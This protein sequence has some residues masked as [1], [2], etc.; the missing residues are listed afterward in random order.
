[1]AGAVW[2]SRGLGGRADFSAQERAARRPRWCTKHS[3]NRE[4]LVT[5]ERAAHYRRLALE[6]LEAARSTSGE[7]RAALIERADFWSRLAKEQDEE[8]ANI[9]RSVPP[10]GQTED[11]PVAQQQQ[12]V[13]PKGDE[14]E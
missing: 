11:Q 12:Q 1:M 4:P 7:L 10:G 2:R 8:P 14:K 6:C 3:Q 5:L 13:Q 9:E